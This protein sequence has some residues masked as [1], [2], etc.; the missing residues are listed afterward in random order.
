M[1]RAPET[2]HHTCS[3][4]EKSK[5]VGFN[6]ESMPE[7]GRRIDMVAGD[8]AIPTT[9]GVGREKGEKGEERRGEEGK[10]ERHRENR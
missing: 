8:D 5:V 3:Y 10:G 4:A 7:Y 1:Q 6:L 9:W 2:G